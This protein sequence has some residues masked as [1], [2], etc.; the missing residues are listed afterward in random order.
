MTQY[1]D[2]NSK[3]ETRTLLKMRYILFYGVGLIRLRLIYCAELWKCGYL[4]AFLKGT[5]DS[6]RRLIGRHKSM[7]ETRRRKQIQLENSNNNSV[8]KKTS[9]VPLKINLLC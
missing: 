3:S 4:S 6:H 8:C 1:G 7:H 2:L 5:G 9:P